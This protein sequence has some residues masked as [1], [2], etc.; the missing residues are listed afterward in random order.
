MFKLVWSLFEWFTAF[1][2]SRNSLGLEI[3]ALRQQVI[4]AQTQASSVEVER[5]GSSLLGFAATRLVP[6]GGGVSGS[7]AG[8][9]R[10]GAS[11]G[12]SALLA[13]AFSAEGVGQAENWFPDSSTDRSDGEGKSPVGSSQNPR[14]ACEAGLCRFGAHC[15][16]IPRSSGP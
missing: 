11:C 2:R 9:R 5:G 10:R 15:L 16:S 7:E 6:L 12:I 1:L 14:R 13:L 3:V 4:V 8:D